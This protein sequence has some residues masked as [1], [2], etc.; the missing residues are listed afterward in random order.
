MIE[1]SLASEKERMRTHAD[2]IPAQDLPRVRVPI[3]L[4][5]TL[6]YLV[7]AILLAIGAAYVITQ[8][9]FDTIEERFTNQL[10][11]AGKLASEWMV[12]EEQ[13]RL[14][15]LRELKNAEGVA[16]AMQLGDSEALRE[17][18]LGIAV[19]RAEEAVEFLDEDGRHVLAMRKIPGGKQEEYEY[20]KGGDPVFLQWNFVK[21]VYADQTDDFGDKY[22]GLVLSDWGDYFFVSGPVYA[23][24]GE[25]V[26]AILVGKTLPSLLEEMR[27]K[28]LAH[29]TL[30]DF[31]G[32][33][34]ATTFIDPPALEQKDA[35]TV[36]ARQDG[37]AVRRNLDG[38]RDLNIA[39]I[40]Y[41][42][43]LGPWEARHDADLG[44]LGVSLVKN[45]YVSPSLP[46]R[47]QISILVA[48]AL[49]LVILMGV[50]LAR[51]ITGPLLGLVQASTEVAHGNLSIQVDPNSDDEVAVLAETFNQ[52][53]KSLQKS[54]MDLIEAYD[55][56]LE[57]WARAV[58]LREEETGKHTNRVTQMTV[59]LAR[60]MGM[61]D[62]QIPHI[63]RGATLHDIGKIGVPD[64]ILLKPGK[65]DDDE[66]KVMHKHPEYAY[67]MLWHIDFLRPAIEIPYCHHE[68]W[69]GSGYP[70]G[71]KGEQIPM[72]ARIFAVVDVWDALTSDRPYRKSMPREQVLK[73]IQKDSGTHFDPRVVKVFMAMLNG[74]NQTPG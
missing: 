46:T 71:L 19:N 48:L 9:V 66:W 25:F 60:E 21:K 11:E 22:S 58:E 38:L 12:R 33:A 55:T 54:K 1:Q 6:P 49:L 74:S 64:A 3:R 73:I 24:N 4:K 40:E 72:A 26:G 63:R 44:I 69:D 18:A 50:N 62:E 5:I 8:I 2:K 30:Y 32:R 53:V 70:R 27:K 56:T 16:E 67:E 45:F 31:E 13:S 42:E 17:L 61:D 39:N 51:Y 20:L 47:V 68:K 52:M 34:I 23:E 65:L 59:Q 15:T 28:T 36:V 41:A 35:A 43:I 7:L 29:I 57:G 14:E 10:I 37:S